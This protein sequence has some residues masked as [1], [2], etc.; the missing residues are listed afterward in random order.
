MKN[1]IIAVSVF[2]VF[3]TLAEGQVLT[4]QW[5]D[6]TFNNGGAARSVATLH[7]RIVVGEQFGSDIVIRGW[8]LQGHRIWQDTF[9]GF[10]VFVETLQDEAVALA[11]IDRQPDGSNL[12]LRGYDLASG[13]IRWT[14]F[15]AID[16]PQQVLVDRGR[17]VIVG[18]HGTSRTSDPLSGLILAFDASTGVQLWR[19]EVEQP[20][21]LPLQDTTFWD[22]DDANNAVIVVGTIGSSPRDTLVQSYRLR[23]GRKRWEHRIPLASSFQLRV[24][25]TEVFVGGER[26]TAL[27]T[28]DGSERWSL[29]TPDLGTLGIVSNAVLLAD[30]AGIRVFDPLTGT[31][32][33][34]F[35]LDPAFE[36]ETI[37]RILPIAGRI[38]TVGTV[39]LNREP[40]FNDPSILIL[41]LFDIAGNLLDEER[42]DASA[43]PQ[44]AIVDRLGHLILVGSSPAGAFVRSYAVE[45]P[46]Q[47]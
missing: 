30:R 18:Y 39:R 26:L 31:V 7:N 10:Q 28:S 17:I 3:T 5:E 41:R 1:L 44:D 27:S 38:L 9:P 4:L 8:N 21:T 37:R 33:W 24:A 32:V 2:L 45:E 22:I 40:G 15:G 43:I 47:P 13:A 25:G 23:D 20:S 34:S 11:L 19:V 35:A 14:S 36:I 16:A 29:D 12:Q 46:V 42:L 6:T